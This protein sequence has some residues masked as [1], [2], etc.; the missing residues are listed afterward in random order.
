MSSKGHLSKDD[1][2]DLLDIIDASLK[3][4]D[5]QELTGVIGRLNRLI[6]FD[7]AIC[8]LARAD[9]KGAIESFDI[10][11]ISYP[12]EWLQHYFEKGYLA[13]DPVVR[14]NFTHFRCQFWDRTYRR[15]RPPRDFVRDAQDFGL[16]A[17]Y[18]YGLKN[19]SNSEGSLFSFAGQSVQS[20]PRNE[21]IIQHIVPHL[22]QALVRILE[23][24]PPRQEIF[25]T[26]REKEILQW[27]KE[28]KSS[29]DIS[30]IFGISTRTVNYHIN[31]VKQKLDAVNRAHAVAIGFS[32]GLIDH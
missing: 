17:G 10:A 20:H 6:P 14:E 9:E 29:W 12:E 26:E 32:Q 19:R 31:N 23:L 2:L 11:N 28:G 18:T 27:V 21:V 30:V 22:H 5:K 3:C 16:R 4:T 24:Q 1:A 13:V 8:A 7:A 15:L 25:L